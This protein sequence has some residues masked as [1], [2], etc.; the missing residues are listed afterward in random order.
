MKALFLT[1]PGKTAVRQ[2][3]EPQIGPEEVLLRIGMVAFVA[4]I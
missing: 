4:E 1:E 3:D 2:V